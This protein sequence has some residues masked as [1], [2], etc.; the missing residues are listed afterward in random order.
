MFDANLRQNVKGPLYSS[1][2]LK[3]L[4]SKKQEKQL[5]KVSCSKDL[6]IG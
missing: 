3:K 5:A 6:W 2:P 1:E 4:I